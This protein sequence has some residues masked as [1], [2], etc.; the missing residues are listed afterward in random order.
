MTGKKKILL[1]MEPVYAVSTAIPVVEMPTMQL[2]LS[3]ALLLLLQTVGSDK[4]SF[5]S[6]VYV[7][8][9]MVSDHLD[10]TPARRHRWPQRGV[11]PSWEEP[12]FC[13]ESIGTVR[14]ELYPDSFSMLYCSAWGPYTID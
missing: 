6:F 8:S 7:P 10:T 2:S 1:H 11:L 5:R 9:C 12:H 13:S 3:A 4:C 14:V